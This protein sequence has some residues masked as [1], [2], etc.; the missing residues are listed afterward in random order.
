[1]A[2]NG[3]RSN[4]ARKYNYYFRLEEHRQWLLDLIDS[5]VRAGR[6]LVIPEFRVSELRNAVEKL[7]GDL[8]VSRPKSR[9]S[10]GIEFPF[11]PEYVTYVWF[12][13]LVNYI[14]FAPGYDPSPGADLSEFH[15]YWPALHVI[16]KDILIPAHGVYWPIMLRALGFADDAI[17]EFLVHGWWNNSGEKMSKSL[18]NSVDP[19]ALATRFGGEALRHYLVSGIATGKDADFS[20]ERLIASFNGDLAN[21]VGNLLNRTLSMAR[22]YREGVLRKPAEHGAF[23]LPEGPAGWERASARYADEFGRCA[24]SAALEVPIG[25]AVLCNQFIQVQQPWVL[26]KDPALGDRLDAVLY[27]LADSLRIIAILLAPIL[28]KAAHGIF[29][30]LNLHTEMR[31][32]GRRFRFGDVEWGLIPDG[33]RVNAPVPLFPRIET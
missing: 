20:E 27:H 3:V 5:R 14:S 8:C 22:S 11:D 9:L 7:A 15:S 6:P 12:D 19:D 30:Q 32:D 33:H 29:D 10:W 28:P 18:G 21:N 1:M 31:G 26:K 24:V 2:R 25:C 17:P 4:S 16:G 13:A 23:P